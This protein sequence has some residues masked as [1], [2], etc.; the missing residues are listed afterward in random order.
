M[1]FRHQFSNLCPPALI[2]FVVSMIAVLVCIMQN[3]GSKNG[4]KIG[5]MMIK[6]NPIM[7]LVFKIIF[8]LFWTWILS[9]I[10]KAG[11]VGI[12][13]L[14]ILAPFILMLFMAL[15]IIQNAMF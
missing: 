11:Y 13:W 5:S 12:S 3:L 15:L 8:I 6:G 10:C 2:Y 14:L 9:L 7:M 1:S 4:C